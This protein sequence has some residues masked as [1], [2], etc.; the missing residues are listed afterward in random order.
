[1]KKAGILLI[2]LAI[3]LL[4]FSI[5]Q[6]DNEHIT[7]P[8]PFSTFELKRDSLYLTHTVWEFIRVKYDVFG[9][10]RKHDF[11]IHYLFMLTVLYIALIRKD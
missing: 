6:R 7:R 10:F 2:V 9:Y 8:Y 4:A 5:N 3:S 11:P 1:M